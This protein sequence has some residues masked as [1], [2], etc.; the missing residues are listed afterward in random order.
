MCPLFPDD[1]TDI[2]LRDLKFDHAG[3]FPH[4]FGDDDVIREVD[5]GLDHHFNQ[6]FQRSILRKSGGE[7]LFQ[8]LINAKIL[9]SLN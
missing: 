6:L 1:F 4:N 3:V 2:F 7:P 5:E 8:R 9:A